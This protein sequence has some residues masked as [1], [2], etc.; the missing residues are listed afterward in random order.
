LA[1]NALEVDYYV[2]ERALGYL[3]R[4]I[5]LLDPEEPVEGLPTQLPKA[6]P[7]LKGPISHVLAP[8]V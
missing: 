4:N 7:P 3:F 2:L 6:N 5:E 8:L 1:Q